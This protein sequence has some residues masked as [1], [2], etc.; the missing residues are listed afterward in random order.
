[1]LTRLLLR[2]S[3]LS[4]SL[5]LDGGGRCLSRVFF[6]TLRVAEPGH[7]HPFIRLLK[8]VLN[9]CRSV[10]QISTAVCSLTSLCHLAREVVP[11]SPSR[12]LRRI[13]PG[14]QT[15]RA[16][17]TKSVRDCNRLRWGNMHGTDHSPGRGHNDLLTA[18][19]R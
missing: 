15:T 14:R 17:F 2:L 5:P 10:D 19:N 12:M 4:P 9:L 13:A 16:Q 11:R 6:H 18:S 1:M 7:R 3:T 8:G